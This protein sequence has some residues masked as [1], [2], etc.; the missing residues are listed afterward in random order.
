MTARHRR[1]AAVAALGVLGMVAL[2]PAAA[3]A[4]QAPSSGWWWTA[5]P[6]AGVVPP[7]PTVPSGGTRVAWSLAGQDESVTAVRVQPSPGRTAL[8]VTLHVSSQRGLT[9]GALEALT[10][11]Q[12]FAAGTRAGPWSERPAPTAGAHPLPVTVD[13]TTV[14]VT[15]AT[16]SLSATS[17]LLGPSAAA[18]DSAATDLD[19]SFTALKA[20]DVTE[21]ESVPSGPAPAVSEPLAPYPV[22]SLSPATGP[23]V[24]AP[25]TVPLEAPPSAV[26]PAAPTPVV[27][28][29]P[30]ALPVPAGTARAFAVV[31]ATRSPGQTALLLGCLLAALFLLAAPGGRRRRVTLTALP[32]PAP[33]G[34]DRPA[35]WRRASLYR[36]PPPPAQASQPA[37]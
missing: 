21:T 22:S 4:A 13:G 24:A 5:Q 17:F 11:G 3:A 10:L 31:G 29:P 18:R 23:L 12:R 16:G 27:A 20:H 8:A 36:L 26:A 34:A 6:A 32:V 35:S 28:P 19:V 2:A 14:T 33:A 1:A 15:L 9:D 37:D 25:P 30:Q 7:P